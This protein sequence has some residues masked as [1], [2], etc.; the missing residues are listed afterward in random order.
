M[1]YP[2]EMH[3]TAP[4]G[5][6]AETITAAVLAAMPEYR[7]VWGD[8]FIVSY[9]IG[10]G[11]VVPQVDDPADNPETPRAHVWIVFIPND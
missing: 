1:R 4:D 11:T 7:N 6:P 5:T 2:L 3:V 9:A 8:H 10:L